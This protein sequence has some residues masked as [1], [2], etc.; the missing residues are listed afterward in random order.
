MN[1]D[2]QERRT[3]TALAT[4]EERWEQDAKRAAAAE[5]L[6]AGTWLSSKGGQLA[7]GEEVLPGAQA[8]LIVLDSIA[9]NT[10]YQ[11]R[12]DPDNPLP[13][14]CFAFGRDGEEM[15]PHIASMIKDQDYF[16]PQHIVGDKI[17]GCDGCPM[18]EWGSADEGRGKACQNRRRLA[19]IPA[20]YYQPKRGSRDM[21][22]HLFTEPDHF[23]RAEVAFFKL[24]VTSVKNWANYVHQLASSMRRPPHGVVTQLRI[25]PNA[26]TQYEAVFEPI[27]LVPDELAEIIMQRHA[28]LMEQPHQGYAAPLP[29]QQQSHGRGGF[30][31]QPQRQQGGRR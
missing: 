8:A 31:Q 20:G 22:L 12:Y 29:E 24:S 2:I 27:E 1:T 21:D 17:A 28:T 6:Q 3:G 14:I 15:Y 16:M 26:K 19:V 30:R 13:P 9:E 25:I 18:N 11:G 4:Y 23:Q 7:I 5:P 10:F